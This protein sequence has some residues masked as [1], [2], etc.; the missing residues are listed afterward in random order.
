M[1]EWL[2]ECLGA[3][4]ASSTAR[5]PYIGQKWFEKH[6]GAK[7]RVMHSSTA[8]VLGILTLMCSGKSGLTIGG[9]IATLTHSRRDSIQRLRLSSCAAML[10]PCS[11]TES[12]RRHFRGLGEVNFY[13]INVTLASSTVRMKYYRASRRGLNSSKRSKKLRS[14]FQFS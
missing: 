1:E 5:V 12:I 13:S 6:V 8:S 10:W 14:V 11:P 9:P 2:F 4:G 7:V 3:F